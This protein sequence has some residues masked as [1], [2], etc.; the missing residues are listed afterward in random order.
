MKANSIQVISKIYLVSLF[1]FD[2]PIYFKSSYGILDHGLYLSIVGFKSFQM[3]NKDVTGLCDFLS[4][5]DSI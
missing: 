1:I 4:F 5:L 2:P 3:K